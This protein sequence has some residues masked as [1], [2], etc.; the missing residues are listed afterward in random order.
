M[1]KFCLSLLFLLSSIIYSLAPSQLNAQTRIQVHGAGKLYPV[2]APTLCAASDSL[3]QAGRGVAG[4]IRR[5]LDIAGYFA[6]IEPNLYLESEGKC[7]QDF[8]YSDWSIINA[9]GL[10]KGEISGGGSN[11]TLKFYLHDV[12]KQS[13]VLAKE[14][15][16]SEQQLTAMAHR[17]VNEVIGYFTGQKGVFGSKIA[18]S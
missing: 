9:E 15:S 18:F 8:A 3:M 6:V 1:F 13:I 11:I 4:T 14:Y 5:S 7:S 16:G 17:F 12:P 10:I 2:A